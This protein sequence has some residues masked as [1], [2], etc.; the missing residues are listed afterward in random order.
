MKFCAQPNTSLYMMSND[1]VSD[2]VLYWYQYNLKVTE[3]YYYLS[4]LNC[5]HSFN[6]K[7]QHLSACG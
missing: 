4:V 6:P 3:F 5:S 7:D 2:E 1:K